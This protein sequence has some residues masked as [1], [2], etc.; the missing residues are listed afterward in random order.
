MW[1]HIRRHSDI[2]FSVRPVY[3]LSEFAFWFRQGSVYVCCSSDA[4]RTPSTDGSQKYR[5]EDTRS[6]SMISA[7]QGL[8][9]VWSRSLSYVSRVWQTLLESATSVYYV[10][11]PYKIYLNNDFYWTY[12]DSDLFPTRCKFTHFIYLWKTAVHVSR[13]IST[14]H[15]EHTH[16]YLS[17]RYCY[18]SP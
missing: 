2:W 4:L 8:C 7:G 11:C 1:F 10:D 12:S 15:Q 9:T 18:L 17:N 13:G 6:L 5:G 14:H 16:L 3:A